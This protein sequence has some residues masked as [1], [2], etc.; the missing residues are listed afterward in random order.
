[1]NMYRFFLMTVLVFT[2]VIRSE[3]LVAVAEEAPSMAG[4]A[5]SAME[6]GIP[7]DQ[8]ELMLKPLTKTELVIEVDAWLQI[9]KAKV[10]QISDAEIAVKKKNDQIAK[11]EE[12]AAAAREAGKAAEE[13]RKARETASREGGLDTAKKAAEAAKVAEEKVAEVKKVAEEAGKAEKQTEADKAI[14]AATEDALK[15]AAEKAE[16]T[17]SAHRVPAPEANKLNAG[18]KVL[19]SKDAKEPDK[20]QEVAEA[21]KAAAGGEAEVKIKLLKNITELRNERT[22]LIDRMNVVLNELEKK[23]GEVEDYSKYVTAVSGI[24]IDVTDSAAAW[25]S[26]VGWLN[27]E[28]GG[29]RWVWNIAKF[30]LIIA[31]FYILSL[32]I[33]KA[34]E[35]MIG[36]SRR[37]SALLRDFLYKAVRRT[38]IILGV[39][40]ALAALEIN[41]G[42]VMAV[43]GAAGFVIAFAL[44]GTLS[45][46]A[47]GIM[48]LMYRPFDV[49]DIVDAGG[50]TGRVQSTNLVS[51]HIRTFDNKSMIV[52][53][54]EIWG[55]VITNSTGARKRR[56]DMVFGI[57]YGDDI[58]KAQGI[59]EKITNDHKLVLKDPEPVIKVHE[60]ADSSVN[61]ICRPWVKT[62][63]YWTV[64]WDVTR[65]VKEEFDRQGVSIPFPQRDVHLYREALENAE[66]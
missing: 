2:C 16:E 31:A 54:N 46:F 38:V 56:V 52:P 6:P 5:V 19:K 33:G 17:D 45:N 39:I 29:L 24:K 50:V 8:L 62:A 10:K 65:S 30:L 60:L 25:T 58:A 11:A 61:F 63:D 32:I 27:S 53:N 51:T 28:E 66:R 7:L 44:Q 42:P 12:V 34:V 21:A 13:A 23:G 22:A 41:I 14:R 4:T 47:S 48:I 59:L 49:G 43:I 40:M 64:Y 55:G 9:L 35:K 3:A 37:V 1:M 20:L 18:A 26:I 57:G 36:T 15:K